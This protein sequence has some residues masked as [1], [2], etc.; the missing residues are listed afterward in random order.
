MIYLTLVKKRVSSTSQWFPCHPRLLKCNGG[1]GSVT[2]NVMIRQVCS[3]VTPGRRRGGVFL[4][5]HEFGGRGVAISHFAGW[6]TLMVKPPKHYEE[7][8]SMLI[9]DSS[10]LF[11]PATVSALQ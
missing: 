6:E 3:D 1:R 4:S 2:A 5:Y 7:C 10:T 9:I 8:S 11:S